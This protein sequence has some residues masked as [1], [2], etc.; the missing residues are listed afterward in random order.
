[1]A[2]SPADRCRAED[3]LR[4]LET[5]RRTALYRSTILH[6]LQAFRFDPDLYWQRAEE[7]LHR[8]PRTCRVC[9]CSA[10]DRCGNA[11]GG[12]ALIGPF[13]APGPSAR[14]HRDLQPSLAISTSQPQEQT[15][16]RN[17][18]IPPECAPGHQRAAFSESKIWLPSSSSANRRSSAC[19]ATRGFRPRCSSAPTAPASGRTKSRLRRKAEPAPR[20]ILII[21]LGTLIGPHSYQPFTIFRLS[22]YYK[23]LTESYS[24]RHPP[25]SGPVATGPHTFHPAAGCGHAA[26]DNCRFRD[27]ARG[28]PRTVVPIACDSSRE[29]QP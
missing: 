11:E 20:I 12:T 10:H 25:L 26:R 29:E 5:P 3:F 9:D 22:T 16:I 23:V 27:K 2:D 17:D 1:M 7:P 13:V 8:Q 19:I 14:S 18:C 28:I 6:L 21:G 4:R 15:N 24:G